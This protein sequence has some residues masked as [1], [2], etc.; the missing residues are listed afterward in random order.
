M[1]FNRVRGRV[2]GR[3]GERF[4]VVGKGGRVKCGK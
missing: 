3:K 1:R 4:M 2:N